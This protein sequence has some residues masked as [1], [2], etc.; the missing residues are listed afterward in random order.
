MRRALLALIVLA[1]AVVG[2]GCPCA[3]GAINASP[4]IRWWLFSNFGASKMCP[5]MLKRGVPLKLAAFGNA[6]VGRFFPSSCNVQVDDS[7]QVIVMTAAGTGYVTLPFTRRVGFYV[8]MAVEYAPDFRLE[9]DAMYVWGKFNRFTTQPDMRIQGVENPV[10]NLATRTPVG[11]VAT[12]IGNGIVASEI[13]KGFTVVRQDDGDDFA[14]GHLE[15]PEKPKRQFKAGKGRVMLATDLTEVRPTSRD[16]LGPFEITD[17]KAALYVRAKIQGAPVVYAVVERS[18]GDAWRRA[19]ET[20]Q[21][22][23]PPPGPV[24]GQGAMAAGDV[25]LAFPLERGSYYL[26]VENQAPAP[27]APLGVAL[28]GAEQI[29]YV[30]YIAEVGDRD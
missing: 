25:K 3:R 23:T 13:G 22:M 12:I 2:V 6:S 4:G 19:Y 14:I 7:R 20:A 30:S 18:V 26:V 29:A 5:E 11:D 27:F 10:V 21:P 28:P 17:K 16:Y 8:G 9:E 15:P 24:L 1:L